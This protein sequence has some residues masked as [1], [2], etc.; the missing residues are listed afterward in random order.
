MKNY[1]YAIFAPLLAFMGACSSQSAADLIVY[2]AQI[3]TVDST[4]SKATALAVK[5]GKFVAIGDSATVFAKYQS[6]SLLN[7]QNK[8]LYPGFYDGHAHFYGLGQMLD[9][10]DLVGAAS[11]TEAVQRLQ[12]Y[13]AAHPDRVW[14]IG[15][16]W[17][18]NDWQ[19]K[20]F[21]TKEMLDK[22]FP[23]QPVYLTRVDGHAAW[24]NSKAL[25]LAQI[26]AKSKVEGGLV[27][28][29]KDGQ[30]TGIL[31]DN[32]MRLARTANPKPTPAEMRAALLKAQE[33]CFEYGLTNVG[34]AGLS[35]EIIDLID[36]MHQDKTLK[37]RLY[38]MV[39]LSPENVDL[40]LKKGVYQTDRLNVRSFKI[41][42]DGAL[43]SRGACLLKPYNDAPSTGFLLLSPKELETYV[44]KI[45]NSDF[46]AN[47][48]CIGDSANRLM[49]NLYAKYLKKDNNRRWRIEHAQIVN[50]ADVPT[51]KNYRIIPSVQPT[52]ATSDMYWASDRLGAER[53]R[54]G[55]AFKELYAQ[56]QLITFGTD[57]PVEP[58]SPFYT[59]HSAVFR[60]DAKGYPASGYQMENALDRATTLRGMTIW[61]A[62][63]N[64]EE[65]RRGSI[66]VGKD[67]DF[68]ILEKDLMTA[69][70]AELRDIRAKKTYVAGQKVF[71]R[72]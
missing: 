3:Y 7:A 72:P 35:P 5:D 59:F 24:V 42:A 26:T 64:F 67:A 66:E 50:P 28:L 68:V 57:F 10:A 36:Q 62:Y 4:F 70:A 63:G 29:D 8:P 1:F 2:N 9:Q 16:G 69:P 41:Y 19:I 22:A 47:T 48:H 52:H 6:D 43:G 18:Q 46:Q 61:A 13:Q 58:V 11:A 20:T 60:Q 32:A 23:D 44:A 65:A 39:S 45:A 27:E 14:L 55:Y 17:D 37:I 34:D 38:A 21:P 49:L 53:A 15:R 25:Q 71:D 30:P 33:V 40:Y 56:N 51:F 12:K 54:H 31:V